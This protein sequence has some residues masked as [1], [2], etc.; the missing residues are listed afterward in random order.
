MY[1]IIPE[2][3]MVVLVLAL[4]LCGGVDGGAGYSAQRLSWERANLIQS[5]ECDYVDFSSVRFNSLFPFS[6]IGPIGTVIVVVAL[7][8]RYVVRS[9][10]FVFFPARY[11]HLIK[12]TNFL[13]WFMV[14]VFSWSDPIYILSSKFRLYHPLATATSIC[15]KS[16]AS[17]R[18]PYSSHRFSTVHHSVRPINLYT[19]LPRVRL[20]SFSHLHGTYSSGWIIA[21]TSDQSNS[22]C[23]F[24]SAFAFVEVSFST[25]TFVAV[26]CLFTPLHAVI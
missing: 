24:F 26:R 1:F 19:Y 4:V 13:I 17:A 8:L 12:F 11:F 20:I 18:A 9:F 21:W 2:T 25:F 16:C 3:P 10:R 14:F 22:F 7:L 23:C 6:S 15:Y 5:C